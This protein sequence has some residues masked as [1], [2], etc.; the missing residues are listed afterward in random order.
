MDVWAITG[1]PK[2]QGNTNEIDLIAKAPFELQSL[3]TSMLIKPLAIDY[4]MGAHPL[5]QH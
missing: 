1:D 2:G 3:H 4:L 5:I